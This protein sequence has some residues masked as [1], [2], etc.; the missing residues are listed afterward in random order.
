MSGH[1]F[2]TG[3]AS[4]AKLRQQKNG[5]QKNGAETAAGLHFSARHFMAL[6]PRPVFIFLP[7]I[8]LLSRSSSVFLQMC[9][10]IRA[11]VGHWR[12]TALVRPA[13]ASAVSSQPLAYARG[14]V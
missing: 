5:R 11:Q 14:T 12:S 9:P 2:K 6:K 3:F 8:F 7:D 13:A 1:I 4:Q 10:D